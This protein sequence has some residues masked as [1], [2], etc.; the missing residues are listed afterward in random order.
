MASTGA[1][2]ASSATTFMATPGWGRPTAP[3]F[4]G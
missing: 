3:I 4:S 1:T 2:D